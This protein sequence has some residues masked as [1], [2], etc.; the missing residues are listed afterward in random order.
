MRK[1]ADDVE[2]A[3][4]RERHNNEMP[5]AEYAAYYNLLYQ[6]K[7][8]KAEALFVSRL[9]QKL[10][11]A[12]PDK[13][14][15]LDLACGTGRHAMEFRRLGYDIEGSDI[16]SDMI[17]VAVEES[18]KNN[19]SIRFYNE[20]FET[21]G[22][23]GKKYHFVLTMFSAINYLTT[24]DDFSIALRNI[25]SLLHEDGFLIFD[26]WSGNV[27][28]RDFLP[29]RVKRMAGAGKEV[30]RI[31]KTTIDQIAQIARVDFQFLLLENGA[32]VREFEEKHRL[33]YFFLQ[34][35]VD[36]LRANGFE[37]VARCPFMHP[38]RDVTLADWNVTYIARK[39][40]GGL[41]GG[42]I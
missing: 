3:R 15:I 32:I 37:V 27:V 2:G 22:R 10:N 34:E 33:R 40:T 17:A 39:G 36:L 41:G 5:F 9:I 20:S 23:I 13:I 16:S 28:I 7:D 24:Y 8:Y 19:L 6:D 35:L 18:K 31:S 30:I 11:P 12:Q 29:V 4:D 1:D 38:E 26:C 25:L 42:I 14:R 21:T